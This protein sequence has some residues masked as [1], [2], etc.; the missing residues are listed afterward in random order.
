MRQK[1]EW[2][3]G[4]WRRHKEKGLA[5]EFQNQETVVVTLGGRM[6]L[7]TQFKV[8]ATGSHCVF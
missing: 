3:P 6:D 7:K 1:C 4:S 8:V 5:E 2:T